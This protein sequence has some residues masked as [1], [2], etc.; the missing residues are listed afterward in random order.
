MY[1]F[2][3]QEKSIK[4]QKSHGTLGTPNHALPSY[5]KGMKVNFLTPEQ[6]RFHLEGPVGLQIQQWWKEGTT[7][8]CS[9]AQ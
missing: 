6:Q 7:Q 4:K 8:E 3:D 1:L 5:R 2:I 9:S